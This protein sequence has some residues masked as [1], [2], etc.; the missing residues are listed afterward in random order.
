ML[1][2]SSDFY[3]Y[4]IPLSVT[5]MLVRDH[6]ESRKPNLL[7]DVASLF[8]TDQEDVVLKEFMLNIL[9]SHYF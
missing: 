2:D 8:S 4:F 5:L 6:K 1:I 3:H 9:T 7:V